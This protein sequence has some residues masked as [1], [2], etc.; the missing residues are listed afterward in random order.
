M[1]NSEHPDASS[2]EIT[3]DKDDLVASDPA[4]TEVVEVEN[5]R[6]EKPDRRRALDD[7]MTTVKDQ[8]RRQGDRGRTTIAAA[9]RENSKRS[10]V[11]IGAAVFVLIAA[12]AAVVI[13]RLR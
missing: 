7:L 5:Q 9:Y 3:I 2:T 8:A 1:S 6:A 4:Q 10:Q 13:R 12:L 11:G